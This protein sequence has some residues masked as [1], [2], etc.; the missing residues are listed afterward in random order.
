MKEEI[1][2]LKNNGTKLIVT[3]LKGDSSK[4]EAHM[5]PLEEGSDQSNPA[6]RSNRPL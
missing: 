6:L 4:Q 3:P 5:T 2:A 1:E